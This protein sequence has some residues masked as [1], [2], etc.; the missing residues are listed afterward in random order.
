MDYYNDLFIILGCLVAVTLLYNIV[1]M[2]ILRCDRLREREE[3][4][5]EGMTEP[6]V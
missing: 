3:A 6:L 1:L 4:E 2:L 5:A